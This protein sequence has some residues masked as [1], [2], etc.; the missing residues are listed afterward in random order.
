MGSPLDNL[1]SGKTGSGRLDEGILES[2]DEPAR[3][4]KG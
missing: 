1:T 3:Q 4:I 2:K